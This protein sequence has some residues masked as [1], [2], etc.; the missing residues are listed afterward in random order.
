LEAL[1]V[2]ISD[3]TI[4][5]LKDL[6]FVQVGTKLINP[7]LVP[8]ITKTERRTSLPNGTELTEEQFALFL[9]D[10]L[11]S[12]DLRTE[13]PVTTTETTVQ[14]AWDNGNA[15]SAAEPPKAKRTRKS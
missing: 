1:D 2:A 5:T 9:A 13:S 11:K 12:Q 3:A 15:Q 7:N 4:C 6:G 14:C 8:Y 10:N